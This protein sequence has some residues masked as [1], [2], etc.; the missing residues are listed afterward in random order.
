MVER[1]MRRAYR[2]CLDPSLLRKGSKL[3][4]QNRLLLA[5]LMERPR[6]E[7]PLH[8]LL[9]VNGLHNATSKLSRVTSACA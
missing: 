5:Y 8:E 7:V 3:G 4:R 6:R 9:L 2:N 1:H